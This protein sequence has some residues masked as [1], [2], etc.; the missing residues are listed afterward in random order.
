MG[1]SASPCLQPSSRN[2]LDAAGS[3]Q[4]RGLWHIFSLPA[5]RWARCSCRREFMAKGDRKT[6]R[7]KIWRGSHG[8][9]RPKSK[10]K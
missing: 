8:N 3:W 2:R 10:K 9:K 6:T 4:E 1:L 7:G 5:D